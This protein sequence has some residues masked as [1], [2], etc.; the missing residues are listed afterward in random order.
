MDNKPVI[1]CSEC[2]AQGTRETHRPDCP[3]VKRFD[4]RWGSGHPKGSEPQ[5]GKDPRK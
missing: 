4:K 3:K 5:G 1:T 2:G